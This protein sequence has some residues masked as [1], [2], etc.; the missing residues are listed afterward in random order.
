MEFAKVFII[1]LLLLV[2]LYIVFGGFEYFGGYE[3]GPGYKFMPS[4]RNMSLG[5]PVITKP[6]G[7]FVGNREVEDF[8]EIS[9]NAKPFE[10]S[11]LTEEK[12]LVAIDN[13]EVKNGILDYKDYRKKFVLTDDE[14]EKMSSPKLGGTVDD[15]NLYG[16]LEVQLNGEKVFS[17]YVEPKD[18][19]EVFINKSLIK[20]DNEIVIAP[21]SS[22]WRIWAPT[23]YIMKEVKLYSKFFG[24]VSQ[25]FDFN[26]DEKESPVIFSRIILDID[27]GNGTL[28]VKVNG[29][30]VFND[31]P[32]SR[33]WIEFSGIVKQGKNTVDFYSGEG[34]DF[35]INNAQIIIFW[36][37]EA[38][39]TLDYTLEL[40][41]SQCN[42][43]PGQIK[44]KIDKVFGEPTS[45][46]AKIKDPEGNVHSIVA[47]GV[48]QEGK[49]I[50]MDLP[51]DYVGAGKNTVTF[52]VT[53]DG[54]YTISDFR[55][56][57]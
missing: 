28:I 47:Q 30:T 52:S 50:S 32:T 7:D 49:T 8:R 35:K 51:K 24:E 16:R 54:G 22:G 38:S 9:L 6:S 14:L 41:H 33:Q 34:G 3:G 39:E 56:V 10:V 17:K 42:S 12:P 27:D 55:L 45:L 25:S 19:F 53:G 23:V 5:E 1:G 21:E 13:F 48:L 37:R 15:T 18:S 46:L 57:L 36:K 43:L 26:V 11:Y 40:T 31:T 4:S 44:F 20:K 2:A 29:E